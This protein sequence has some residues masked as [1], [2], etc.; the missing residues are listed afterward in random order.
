MMSHIFHMLFDA[1]SAARAAIGLGI[2]RWRTRQLL[3][4][5]HKLRNIDH[6]HDEISTLIGRLRAE[7]ANNIEVQRRSET[8]SK[9]AWH[10]RRRWRRAF[11]GLDAEQFGK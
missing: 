4:E 9:T 11:S 5:L 2:R 3:S 7:L 10:A 8:H 1:T 6:A